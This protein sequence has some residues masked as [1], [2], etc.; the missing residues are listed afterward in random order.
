MK[1]AIVNFTKDC[2]YDSFKSYADFHKISLSRAMI[3]LAKKS[4]DKWEDERLASL[5]LSRESSATTND[6]LEAEAFWNDLNV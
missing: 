2:D 3:E 1:R 4:L 6:Y 5:A